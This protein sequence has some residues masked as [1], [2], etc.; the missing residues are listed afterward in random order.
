MSNYYTVE[1]VEYYVKQHNP[2]S[3]CMKKLRDTKI[4]LYDAWG[5]KRYVRVLSNRSEAKGF[6][7]CL[8]YMGYKK[9]EIEKPV[10]ITFKA[11]GYVYENA[12][13]IGI[14][15]DNGFTLQ[16]QDKD[17]N[18][19]PLNKEAIENFVKEKGNTK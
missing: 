7:A 6:C 10:D 18:V 12:K 8:E 3:S 15:L 14:T 11:K 17:G 16:M 5:H 19:I 13:C 2:N 9:K 1:D 4:T